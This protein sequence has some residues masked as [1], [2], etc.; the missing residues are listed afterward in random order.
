VP[1]GRRVD[2]QAGERAGANESMVCREN[3]DRSDL[4][5]ASLDWGFN[6]QLEFLADQPQ[7]VEPFWAFPG[8]NGRLPALPQRSGYIYLAHSP[9]YSL[10]GYDVSYLN[11]LETSGEAVDI[12]PHSDRQGQVVFYTIQFRE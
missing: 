12:Q 2:G 5:I 10:F 6:E 3:K 11:E 7:L 1:G 8:Y 9:E 4:V